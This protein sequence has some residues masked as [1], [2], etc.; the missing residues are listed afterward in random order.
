MAVTQTNLVTDVTRIIQDSS[1][2]STEQLTFLNQAMQEV[3]GHPLV[4][5]PGLETEAEVTTDTTYP[6]TSLPS[7]YQ[8][9]LFYVYNATKYWEVAIRASLGDML[10]RYH[11]LDQSGTI[12][13]L[14]VRGNVLHYQRIPSSEETLE[15][16]Y[17]RKPYDMA[18]YTADTIS[19]DADAGTI[20]DSASGLGD[21]NVGQ[22]IDVTGTSDNN[23]SFTITAATSAL[24]T[25]SEDVTDEAAGSDFTIKS[26]PD[27]IPDHLCRPLLVNHACSAIFAEIEEGVEGNKTNTIYHDQK[28]QQAIAA[29]IAFI[30]PEGRAP[31]GINDELN[32]EAFL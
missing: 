25:V 8:K 30:G 10:R 17:Y 12:T 9:N 27:G 1:Y 22:I 32:L 24:L 16:H 5:L 14:A 15:I 6:Y 29:L 4:L 23:T 28:F 21:F 19:F 26:R 31:Q 18:T 2:D 20:A 3:A 11:K 7:N 13:S